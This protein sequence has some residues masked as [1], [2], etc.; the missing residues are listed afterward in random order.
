MEEKMQNV[1]E[2]EFTGTAFV[3]F[4]HDRD[5]QKVQE[6]W[7]FGDVESFIYRIVTACG[8]RLKKTYKGKLIHV[9]R[10]P[11]PLDVFWENLGYSFKKLL[12][13]KAYTN[14]WSL[15][16]MGACFGAILGLK[17]GQE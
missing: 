11:E 2:F 17:A 1:S 10:A 7:E 6:K 4:H 16:L 3:S 13:K 14:L 12:K 8:C 9:S 15:L 5:C